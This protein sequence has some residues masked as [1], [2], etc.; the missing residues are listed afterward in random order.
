MKFKELSHKDL[1]ENE[2]EELEGFWDISYK[3]DGVR[4]EVKD[5]RFFTKNGKEMFHNFPE[6]DDGY[7]EM[8]LGS[9]NKS[10]SVMNTTTRTVDLE[11]TAFFRLGEDVDYR[12]VCTTGIHNPKFEWLLKCLD[13]AIGYGY[14][15]L[16]LYNKDKNLYYKVKPTH[17]FDEP[18]LSFVEG[19][20]KLEGMLG[21]VNTP[22]GEVGTGFSEELRQEI[23][24]NKEKYR[25]KIIEVEAQSLSSKGL[26]RFP[27][28]VRLRADK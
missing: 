23:W 14:E 6:L 13:L 5:G 19:K 18:I 7:Y 25:G 10:I 28:F 17:T 1:K 11:P 12:L 27:R 9:W 3:L 4:V 2:T 15:G 21:K 8:F 24:D 26:F 16:V 22:R 20:G